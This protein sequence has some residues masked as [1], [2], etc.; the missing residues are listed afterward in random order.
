VTSSRQ[1]ITATMAAIDPNVPSIR[2]TGP[3]G[4]KYSGRVQDKEALAKVKVGDKLD[5]TWTEV[6]VLSIDESK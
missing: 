1:H 2:F 3:N 4:W 6:L 5:I